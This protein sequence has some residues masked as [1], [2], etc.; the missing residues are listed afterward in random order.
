M[1]AMMEDSEGILVDEDGNPIHDYGMGEEAE[2]GEEDSPDGHMM[3][4]AD[5]YGME[6]SPDYEGEVPIFFLTLLGI[7]GLRS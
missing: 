6:G 2:Y 1:Q 7:A 3:H 4:E 5:S